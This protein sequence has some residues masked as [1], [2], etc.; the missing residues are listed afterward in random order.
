MIDGFMKDTILQKTNALFPSDI[1]TFSTSS[2]RWT[3]A[4]YTISGDSEHLMYAI[5]LSQ[6]NLLRHKRMFETTK[7]G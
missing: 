5:T 7:Q 1:G 3:S 2:L 6:R 4:A